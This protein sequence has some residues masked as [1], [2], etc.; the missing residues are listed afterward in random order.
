MLSAILAFINMIPG[1]SSAVQGIT[2]AYFNSKVQL[3]A[4][5]VGG[6]TKVAMSLVSG[7]TAEGQVRVSFLDTVSHSK[8]LQALIAMFAVP[9]AIYMGKCVLWDTVLGLGTTPALKGDVA[10]YMHIVI[11]GIFGS[12]SVMALGQ[13][14]FN[15]SKVGE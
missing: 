15:R 7:I 13:M 11:Y 4:I 6:D 14:Y 8:F 2:K 12:G 9:V 1:V 5:R 10:D 3:A